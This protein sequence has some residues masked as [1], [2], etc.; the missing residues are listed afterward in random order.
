MY[1]TG[2]DALDDDLIKEIIGKQKVSN[3]DAVSD[4][5]LLKS[6]IVDIVKVTKDSSLVLSSCGSVTHFVKKGR[7][8]TK[9]Q[10]PIPQCE[11]ILVSDG[12]CYLFTKGG[13]IFKLPVP[14]HPSPEGSLENLCSGQCDIAEE[15][16]RL[17]LKASRDLERMNIKK[18]DLE[19]CIRQARICLELTPQCL[20][21]KWQV[22]AE[23]NTLVMSITNKSNT[24]DLNGQ[25]WKLVVTVDASQYSVKVPKRFRTGDEW[26]YSVKLAHE[27]A[28]QVVLKPLDLAAWLVFSCGD[29]VVRSHPIITGSHLRTFD[30]ASVTS[31]LMTATGKS[32]A[33]FL[34]PADETS[35]EDFLDVIN[36]KRA[37]GP[38]P[39]NLSDELNL[40]TVE[41]FKEALLKSEAWFVQELRKSVQDL[42]IQ[43]FIGDCPVTAL[44]QP[45]DSSVKV[46]LKSKSRTRILSFKRDL[47]W[48]NSRAKSKVSQ[49]HS[50]LMIVRKIQA[51]LDDA[52]DEN[53][54][55]SQG[56]D[57]DFLTECYNRLRSSLSM[58]K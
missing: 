2:L 44:V 3:M 39:T 12:F 23:E 40:V 57:Q 38:S 1:D 54:M 37:F 47:L 18:S 30:F 22:R 32:T 8:M 48:L 13:T 51:T 50:Q 4:S 14:I 17:I 15:S 42:S 25:Y 28:D 24:V 21:A 6:Q 43:L 41:I 36:H 9:S 52:L 11:R 20:Q 53:S 46:T 56:V 34:L 26:S 16:S 35:F 45:S 33:P 19:G 49:Q 55:N 5:D 10:L 29:S 7:L 31:C 58:K 27:L